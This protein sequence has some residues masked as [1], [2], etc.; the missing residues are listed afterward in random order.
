MYED[1]G[2]TTVVGEE[3]YHYGRKGMKW[4]QH[5]YG[6]VQS[7]AK[8]AKKVG[9]K[10]SDAKASHDEKQKAKWE[11]K[12]ESIIRS[13]DAKTIRKNQDKLSDAELKRAFDRL[14][15]TPNDPEQ[16]Q[17][18]GQ[19][20]VN[21]KGSIKAH[22]LIKAFSDVASD[23]DTAYKAVDKLAGIRKDIQKYTPEGRAKQAKIDDIMRNLKVK[24]VI[25]NPSLLNGKQMGDLKKA[26]KDYIDIKD[27]YEKQ[28]APAK[29][30]DS[31][32]SMFSKTQQG[33]KQYTS[34]KDFKEYNRIN[35]MIS[36]MSSNQNQG[37]GKGKGKGN[38]Q[39]TYN[40]D[41][42]E[43]FINDTIDERLE[44]R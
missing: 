11:E 7:V 31:P 35:N 3:L 33:T 14:K 44:D 6:P 10:L 15:N 8:Y 40:K 20:F 24:E 21:K 41:E 36:S 18:Q 29:T 5:I 4:Y 25:D 27:N 39:Q 9:S 23:I 26:Y 1:I 19:D 42:I 17:K 32:L 30:N 37:K 22:D 34:Y 28:N 13:G 38:N 2:A 43:R 16:K 12:K